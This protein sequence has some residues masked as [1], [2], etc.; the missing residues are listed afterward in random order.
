VTLEE[1]FDQFVGVTT[2]RCLE[3]I[4]LRLGRPVPVGFMKQCEQR[5]TAA[6][7]SELKP[8]TGIEA[9]LDGLKIPYCVASNGTHAK[10]NT[11]LGLTGLLARFDGKRVS[12]SDV[13]RGKP[14]PDVFL[15]SAQN[16]KVAPQDCAVVED[17]PT[18]VAA[19]VAAGMTVFGY[20][21][22]M[23][24]RRLREAGAHHTFSRMQDLPLLLQRGMAHD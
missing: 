21:A 20:S 17:T 16:F 18:G 14:F 10:M 23:P 4:E 12:V 6:L 24:A 3:M 9:V 8:V 7:T 13:A 22:H 19:G 15:R 11:T 1:V 2:A 5:T